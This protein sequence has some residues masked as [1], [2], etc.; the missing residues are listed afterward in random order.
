M[1]FTYEDC[2]GNL[3]THTPIILMEAL[4]RL[5]HVCCP[6]SLNNTLLSRLWPSPDS[7]V[8][9]VGRANLPR[10]EEGLRCLQLPW[11]CLWIK[12]HSPWLPPPSSETILKDQHKTHCFLWSC[13]TFGASFYSLL[14]C[15]SKWL[16]QLSTDNQH[17]GHCSLMLLLTVVVVSKYT[18]STI[19]TQ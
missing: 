15:N 4:M 11:S 1:E 12:Y 17:L 16:M 19:G 14:F 18:V 10:S 8:T 9:L 3:W 6:S 2:L 7:A 13:I 5:S